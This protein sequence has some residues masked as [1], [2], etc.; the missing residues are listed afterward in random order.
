M[1]KFIVDTMLGDVAKWLRIMGYDVA[2]SKG[3]GDQEI[4]E[5]AS[6]GNRV[7]I[8][9]DRRLYGKAKKSSLEAVL[10]ESMG[11]PERIAEVAVKARLELRA[12]PS[13]SRCP[14]CNGELSP[15]EDKERVRDKVPPQ[16]LRAYRVFYVCTR[17][18][19]VYWEGSHWEN[20]RKTLD[21][22]RRIAESH[23]RKAEK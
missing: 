9:R 19:N 8:T 10:V 11:T 20:I 18:G 22:A 13:L 6:L 2:Y 1:K 21:L 17:C 7:I 3:Y 15:T 23:Q 4:L 12:D 14:E 5:A 16:A